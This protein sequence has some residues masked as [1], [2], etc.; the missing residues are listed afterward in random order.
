MR[1]VSYLFDRYGP[2][3]AYAVCFTVNALWLFTGFPWLQENKKISQQTEATVNQQSLV[4]CEGSFWGIVVCVLGC[5]CGGK[6]EWGSE[7]EVRVCVW[8]IM[9]K[10]DVAK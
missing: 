7:R 2:S 8:S 5:V 10:L 1:K 4:G 6:R 3:T 9:K